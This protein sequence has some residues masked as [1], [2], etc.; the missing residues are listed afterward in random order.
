LATDFIAIEKPPCGNGQLS[1]KS[2]FATQHFP[3]NALHQLL[4][5]ANG[6]TL[7]L[8]GMQ[9]MQNGHI[10]WHRA[11]KLHDTIIRI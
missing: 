9:P 7:P 6:T 10:S 5:H 2:S 3:I 4:N 1:D 8:L 11:A